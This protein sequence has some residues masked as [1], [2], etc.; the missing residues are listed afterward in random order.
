MTECVSHPNWPG[1]STDSDAEVSI[2]RYME[3]SL[4]PP[5]VSV[6]RFSLLP[7]RVRVTL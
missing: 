4:G 1:S 6:M 5:S 7:T 2:L 3:K